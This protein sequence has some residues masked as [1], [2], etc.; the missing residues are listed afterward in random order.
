MLKEF[1]I[2]VKMEDRW[3]PH[4]QSLLATMQMLGRRG[5]S[6]L[7]GFYSDGDGD[8]RPTFEFDIPV[9]MVEGIEQQNLIDSHKDDC[10][11]IQTSP[12]IIPHIMFDAG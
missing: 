2:N 7:L 6:R 10:Y 4:F 3:V 11:Q 9:T 5:S 1:N 8:F 12:S